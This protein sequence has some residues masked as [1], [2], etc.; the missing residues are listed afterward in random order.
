MR[1]RAVRFLAAHPR[2]VLL[3]ALW[4]LLEAGQTWLL[5]YALARA[6]DD[7]F[8]AGERAVGLGWLAAAAGAV[9]L[10]AYGTGQVYRQVAALVEPARDALVRR[11][12]HRALD[13][14]DDAAVSRLTH[15]V[16]IARDALAGLILV[17]RSFVFTAVGALVGLLVLAPALLLV[18]APPL[19]AGLALFA[20]TLR[21]LARR[22]ERF[23]AADEAVSAELG[24]AV[25]ALRD[26]RAAGAE[27][28]VAA[29]AAGT[30]DAERAA[31]ESVARWAGVRVLAVSVGGRL[32]ILL[33]LVTAPWL[34][35]QGVSPGALAGALVYL[36]Q[37]LLPALQSLVEG[38]GVTGSRLFVVL[39]RLLAAPALRP[40]AV[41]GAPP[42]PYAISLKQV[43]FAYGPHAE[44]V[45]DRLDL[46]VPAGAHLAVTGPSGS[47]KSTLTALVAGLLAPGAGEV[48]AVADR[49][50]VPQE[51]YVFSGTV[52]ENLT[53]LCPRPPADP[54]VL[55]AAERVGA[56]EL[57]RR[58]G[59]LDAALDPGALSAGERQL[60]ALTRAYL[61]PGRLV[62]LD[63]AASEL[64]PAAELHAERAFRARPAT[65]LVVVA[66]RT[67]AAAR[68]DL[69]LELDGMEWQL[70]AGERHRNGTEPRRADGQGPE[71]RN[72]ADPRQP[73]GQKPEHPDG[74]APWHGKGAEPRQPTRNHEARTP[75][76]QRPSDPALPL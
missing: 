2:E 58:A 26:I 34:L 60:L 46:D 75:L 36:T 12:V 55:A 64:D 43:T 13:A 65:T 59:G 31:A 53:Y 25:G 71:H 23:L 35:R 9:V 52:R 32:P 44:P 57:V 29:A 68:A 28:T 20:A 30:V 72:G 16:E 27:R 47:G 38:L 3:L 37:S 67:A 33:L 48:R 51:A 66:H 17:L 76:P 45:L 15:Q 24:R 62:L 74:R 49:V 56:A 8:L 11:V 39:R 18:V 70:R 10:A 40:P 5:G 7:G 21:P 14:P 63:E 22:Q 54:D 1:G 4:S 6:L 42:D 61:A 19:A 73:D 69:V 41:P 50:L